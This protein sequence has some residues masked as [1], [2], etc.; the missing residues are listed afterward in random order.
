MTEVNGD[1]QERESSWRV[2]PGVRTLDGAGDVILREG[3]Q[4]VK[5]EASNLVPFV[6]MLLEKAE[7]GHLDLSGMD[8]LSTED[9]SRIAGVVDKLAEAGLLTPADDGLPANAGTVDGLWNRAGEEISRAEISRRLTETRVGVLGGGALAARVGDEL[10]NAGVVLISRNADISTV[11]DSLDVAVVV[12]QAEEDP[13]FVEWNERAIERGGPTWLA[14]TPMDGQRFTVGPWVFPN[15]S[16]C[17]HCF[18]L[19]RSAVFLESDVGPALTDATQLAEPRDFAAMH[20]TLSAMQATFVADAVLQHVGL[21]DAFGQ[22]QPGGVTTVEYGMSGMRVDNHRVL[23]VPRCSHCS[24]AQGRGFP[25][26]WFHKS[27]E[28]TEEG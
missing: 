1:E 4:V 5:I 7:D 3:G 14:V 16:A 20:P 9:R 21:R 23:R 25:Q 10:A 2:N 22:A 17:F 28:A 24:P 8:T 12:G 27:T 15:S 18:R 11:D 13:L 6:R 26:V 19:R